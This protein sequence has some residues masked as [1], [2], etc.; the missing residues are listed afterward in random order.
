MIFGRSS[1]HYCHGIILRETRSVMSRFSDFRIYRARRNKFL[2][3]YSSN[4]CILIFS[5]Y[6]QLLSMITYSFC[7]TAF[8]FCFVCIIV[9]FSFPAFI[10]Q[11]KIT[12]ESWSSSPGLLFLKIRLINFAWGM[13]HLLALHYFTLPGSLFSLALPFPTCQGKKH[14]II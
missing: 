10:S 13:F 9:S 11:V 7:A 6:L 5:C 12:S 3:Q 2:Q 1:I 8:N 4:K 14:Y